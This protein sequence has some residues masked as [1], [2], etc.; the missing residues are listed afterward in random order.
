MTRL[1]ELQKIFETV[2][3][4]KRAVI[5]P[6]LNQTVEWEEEIKRY[7]EELRNLPLNNKTKEKYM[8]YSKLKREAQQQYC[9]IIK[10]LLMTLYRTE[11]SAADE[12]MAKLSE[13]E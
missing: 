4:D 6:L 8:T 13:F 2:D 11:S 9:N 10:V 3:E 7:S 1:E 12:L 5:T